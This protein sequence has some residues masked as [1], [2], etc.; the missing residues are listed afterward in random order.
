MVRRMSVTGMAAAAL[1]LAAAVASPAAAAPAAPAAHG[2]PPAGAAA[3]DIVLSSVSCAHAARC[4][5]VA[6][7]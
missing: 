5:A 4:L 6:T 2:R 7:T 3:G 1:T